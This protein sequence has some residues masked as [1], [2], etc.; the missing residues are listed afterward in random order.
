MILSFHPIIEADH[1]I[2]CAGREPNEEDLAAI[3]KADAVILHQGC[4][5][6]LYR[7]ARTNCPHI[8]PNL[9]TRFDYPGKC[10][11]IRLFRELGLSHPEAHLFDSAAQFHQSKLGIDFPAVV[12][13]DWGGQGETVYKV[14]SPPEL[15]KVLDRITAFENSGQFGFLIQQFIPTQHRSLRVALINTQTVTYWRIQ[16]PHH[17]FGTSV[18]QGARIDHDVNSEVSAAVQRVIQNVCRRTGL[19]LAGFDFIF[20]SGTLAKGRTEPLI[21]EINYFFGRS[22]L[23]GSDTYYRLLEDEVD[24]WLATLG[25]RRN[26]L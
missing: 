26:R 21:L 15:T 23:G 6:P 18:D 16:A 11:Q 14:D 20:N 8:F 7:M 2:I 13:L 12:K 1:N 25:L 10:G 4:S 17:H 9:D 19:Q 5:E 22:G 24:K 3:Q